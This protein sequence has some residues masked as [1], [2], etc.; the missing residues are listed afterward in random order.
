MS[1]TLRPYQQESVDALLAYF[2]HQKGHPILVL[3]T[4]AGKSV[5]LAEII[6]L[7]LGWNSRCLMTTHVKE[8]VEQN[9]E[10]MEALLPPGVVG[11]NSAGLGRRDF[12]HPV[13]CAGI[14]SVHRHVDRLGA[15]DLVLIDECHLVPQERQGRY[16]E[17]LDELLVLNP[18]TKVVGLTATPYR[19]RGG[20][21]HTGAD[22]IFT[23][24]AHEVDVVRLIQEGFLAPL[25]TKRPKNEIDVSGVKIQGGEFQAKAL[26]LV[27]GEASRVRLAVEEIV[28]RGKDR[29]SWLVFACSVAHAGLIL[30]EL[31]SH[32]VAAEMVTGK[33]PKG[34][35][36]R[37][38]QDYKDGYLRALVSVGVLTTGFD[39]PQ[40]DLLAVLRPT[41]S[42]GLYVQIMGRGMRIADGK[43]DCLVLDFGGNA[44]RHGPV[45]A[46]QII[47]RSASDGE[48][49]APA[50][51]CPE[52]ASVIH[53]A[54]RE[55][56]DCGFLFPE[57]EVK[58]RAK[59]AEEDVLAQPE[60]V[61]LDVDQVS[62]MRHRGK[63]G[64]PDSLRVT[65]LC[66][67]KTVS[68][69]RCFEHEGVA[70]KLGRNWWRRRSPGT[71]APETVGEALERAAAGELKQPRAIRVEQG[72]GAYPTVKAELD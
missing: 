40:T 28:Q 62:Y 53:A 17:M 72:A 9:A 23:D 68:A 41:R 51:E 30:D 57:P 42:P 45:N 71:I 47:D 5:I 44:L 33:T 52:C 22:S 35:R 10:K 32:G 67:L 20:Y 24:I 39:A 36:R 69:W 12:D 50:K 2:Q 31:R 65:Y 63:G 46:I 6:R 34:D 66:G 37:L 61:E 48:D 8:L 49:E 14:Q 19:M 38:I 16:R 58:H 27:V 26:D 64:K 1:Y 11:V 3:P 18:R 70:S 25:T 59:A 60:I 21:L 43:E 56:P 55:C 13:I 4:G 29:R 15:F 7:A 54:L